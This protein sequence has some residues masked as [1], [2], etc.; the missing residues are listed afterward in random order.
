M[1]DPIAPRTGLV[2]WKNTKFR[3]LEIALNADGSSTM[4]ALERHPRV[5]IGQQFIALASEVTWDA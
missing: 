4:V 3:G 1:A 2:N 5:D